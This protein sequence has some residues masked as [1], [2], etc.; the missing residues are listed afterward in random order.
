MHLPF[1]GLA[2]FFGVFGGLA[3]AITLPAT[4]ALRDGIGV[5]WVEHAQVH[6]HLQAVGFVGLF[7]V[8]MSYRLL[9]GFAGRALPYPRLVRPSLVALALGVLARAAGQPLADIDGFA[10]VMV[11]SGWLE[12]AGLLLFAANVLRLGVPQLGRGP[13]YWWFLVTG[14]IW[15]V[16]QGALGAVWLTEL[17]A[18]GGTILSAERGGTLVFLLFFGVH[19]MFILGVGLRAFPTFFAAG[20]LPPRRALAA[21]GLT[22]AGT[23][24]V[25]SGGLARSYGVSSSGASTWAVED[26]GYVALGLGLAWAASFTGFWRAPSRI[27]PASRPSAYLLQ[28]A[29]TWLVLAALLLFGFGL[30][31]ALAG[32]GLQS[33]EL[34]AARHVVGVGVVLSTIAGMA[35]MVLP[36]FAGER[37]LGRQG[38]RRSLLFGVLL[39]LAT[40]LRAGTR[41]LGEWLPGDVVFWSMSLAGVLALIVVG[42]LGFYFVRGV[43]SFELVLEV[44]A[45]RAQDG[46]H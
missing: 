18:E 21:Y 26:A 40:V 3:L 36:E 39:S 33:R 20:P 5:S 13:R 29:M 35:Q 25:V 9:P 11:A 22:Q 24:A 37:L 17:A 32:E 30:A 38:A 10:R 6:G 15:F 42:L 19:L 46:G 14:A 2:F 28:P 23:L 43:R 7:I 31:R 16:T 44:A 27:R 34:D 45:R 4:A 1:I 41:L 12:L 8:G